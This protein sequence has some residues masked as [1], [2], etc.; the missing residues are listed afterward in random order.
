MNFKSEKATDL[1]RLLLI[2]LLTTIAIQGTYA[3]VTTEGREF[4][5]GFME[6]ESNGAVVELELYISAKEASEVT[7]EAPLGNFSLTVNVTPGVSQVVQVPTG[8][9]MPTEEGVFDIGL[10]VTS[11]NPVSLY[12]LNKRSFSADAAVILPIQALGKEYYVTAHVEPPED[13]IE[14]SRESLMLIVAV[15][16]GTEIEITPSADTFEGLV[17]GV[18]TTV[19]LNAG[20]V[21]HIKS[22]GDL[23]GT[24]VRTVSS[25]SDDCKNIAVFGGNVFTNV[26]GCGAARDHLLEQ[27]FPVS[28][29]GKNFLYLPYETRIGG[30]YIK[31]IASVDGTE[32]N[33]TGE[34]VVP[35]DA[36]DVH[37]IKALDGI[38][39]ITSNEPISFA[40]FSRSQSC[41]NTASDP[42]FILVS[43]LEQRIRE[44][45]FNA[46]S[47][48]QIDRY[49]LSLITEAGFTNG[50]FL[51]GVDISSSFNTSGSSAYASL[52]ITQGNHTLQAEDG[53][54]AFV[55]GFG[56]AE[57][58]GYSAG[59]ALENLNLQVEGVDEF[60]DIIQ[61]QACL[62][63]EIDFDVDF[64]TPPGETPRF[65]TFEWDFGNGDVA[66]GQSITYTYPEPGE[67]EL[68][69]V[70]SDGLGSCGTS[71][72]L[73]RTIIIE[74]TIVNELL[75]P[76]S[77]CPDVEDIKYSI[78]GGAGNTYE[79]F[80]NGGTFTIA[81]NGES[82]L[83]DWGSPNREAFV[84]V[85]PQNSIGCKIDTLV[86]PVVVNK[87]LEPAAPRTESVTSADGLQ[88]EVCFVDR[89]R[90]RYFVNPTNGSYYIWEVEGGVFTDDTNPNS[91]EVF[92]NWGNSTSGRVWY[93]EGNNLIEDC[94][95][96][97]DVLNVTIYSQIQSVPT[98]SDVL[99]NGEAT[100]A[101]SLAISGGKPG[102][103]QVNWDNGMT[104]ADI[105]G[106]PTGDYTA[107]ITDELGCQIQETYTVGE[108]D[109]LVIIGT[110]AT[111]PVRC[112]QEANGVA[113]VTVTGG[114]TFANGDYRFTWMSNGNET[115]TT[116]H[117]NSSLR[118][119]SYTVTVTDANGCETSA[120]FVIDEP[121]LLEVD[122]QA[123]INNPI[124]PQATDGT[125][126]IDAKGGT[127]DY[128]FFWS[129]KPTLDDNN[130]TDLS[131]GDYSV[132]IVDANGCQITYALEVT[133]RFPKI[134]IPNAFSPNNDGTNDTFKPVADCESTYFMQ[135]YNKWGSIIFST[136]DIT[137]GWDGSFRNELAPEGE[138][139]YVIFYAGSINGV[140]FEDT[141]RGAFNL[142]R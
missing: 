44:V 87:L 124:C 74:P 81:P 134:Y 10:L 84:K 35:L 48:D 50:I 100:G 123:L 34:D 115:V 132:R 3:Q 7:V 40:Q 121:P 140:S 18:P 116:N 79:W 16:D 37:I 113:D 55:Y 23:S 29:W 120:N 2:I 45:T 68:T 117:V 94:E 1:R 128:Q 22:E 26:G 14:A 6:N 11:D 42:F 135:I 65:N 60:I 66:E 61:Q 72:T 54:I 19:T 71:E 70:A 20:Q 102:E 15:Q 24:Y 92:V 82:I 96:V 64:V 13:R 31:I 108:P 93:T 110:P 30:D 43:P 52:E 136:E 58:F 56:N 63:A 119:G 77:V 142:I 12:A 106:L 122:L 114:V 38:R 21:Y 133:E 118:A 17:A 139:S 129:N 103:Y 137:E 88:A 111:L 51:D 90:V 53:V 73:I 80:V 76:V 112:F 86:L 9:F 83:V 104:G 33:I 69:L 4:W 101:V 36:G 125:A 97:S 47:V 62:N 59:V 131:Q 41:D 49:Y 75:G 107:T 5:L 130:G 98:I 105:T 39:S 67:Y 46:F 91:T 141:Y 27:M 85:L 99:C 126:F 78:S 57:S 25:T 28:T 138:Y 89:N 127:P 109:E 32:V 95:G 8:T